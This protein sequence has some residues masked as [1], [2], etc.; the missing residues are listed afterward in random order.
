LTG[1]E[2]RVVVPLQA[3]DYG[4]GGK[5]DGAFKNRHPVA[6]KGRKDQGDGCARWVPGRCERKGRT[7]GKGFG[8]SFKGKIGAGWHLARKTLGGEGGRSGVGS[9]AKTEGGK[10]KKRERT[11]QVKR[12]EKFAGP[13]R[14]MRPSSKLRP[15]K[16]GKN[17]PKGILPPR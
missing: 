4:G 3:K 14:L 6:E 17:H 5:T 11:D 1:K 13:S 8:G 12:K 7:N 10:R 16:D 15:S 9:I 2:A